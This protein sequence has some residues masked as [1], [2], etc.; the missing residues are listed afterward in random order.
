[1]IR[2][3]SHIYRSRVPTVAQTPDEELPAENQPLV[4]NDHSALIETTA[5]TYALR[6]PEINTDFYLSRLLH[7][8]YRV[9]GQARFQWIKTRRHILLKDGRRYVRKTTLS[10]C[11]ARNLLLEFHTANYDYNVWNRM[12]NNGEFENYDYSSYT[13][14]VEN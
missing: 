4:D 8:F 1:M 14:P 10:Q 7:N 6:R 9:N 13:T 12:R 11:D 5:T 3:V 2:V